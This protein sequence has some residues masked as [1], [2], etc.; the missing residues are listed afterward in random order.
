MLERYAE[1]KIF[2]AHA[3]P[4][5]PAMT[6]FAMKRFAL[7]GFLSLLATGPAV[8]QTD[9]PLSGSWDAT[10][11]RCNCGNMSQ[12]PSIWGSGFSLTVTNSCGQTGTTQWTGEGRFVV[13]EWG[14]G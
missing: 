7:L 13:P 4:R 10:N 12:R 5:G 8:A 6:K 2:P 14:V 3:H 1:L 9:I 11:A